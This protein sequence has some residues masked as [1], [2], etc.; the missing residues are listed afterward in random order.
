MLTYVLGVLDH[1][2]KNADAPVRTTAIAMTEGGTEAIFPFT[3]LGSDPG[4]ISVLS[5]AKVR[6]PFSLFVENNT[7]L[8]PDLDVRLD[9]VPGW[10][11]V[12][13][14]QRRFPQCFRH[15]MHFWVVIYP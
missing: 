10:L 6:S 7:Q 8:R 13:S 1:V 15:A 3:H 2:S 4:A 14:C 5:T 11:H 9:F 12:S